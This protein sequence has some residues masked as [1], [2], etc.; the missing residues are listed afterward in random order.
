MQ[1]ETFAVNVFLRITGLSVKNC[2]THIGCELGAR[3]GGG[4]GATRAQFCGLQHYPF[5][6]GAFDGHGCIHEDEMAIDTARA[7]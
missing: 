5:D 1:L 6:Q 4:G 2:M 3:G 7:D